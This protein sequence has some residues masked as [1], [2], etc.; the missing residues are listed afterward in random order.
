M[1]CLDVTQSEYH[2]FG[3]MWPVRIVKCANPII[4]TCTYEYQVNGVV[5]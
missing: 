4:I 2:L 1:T 5:R 3:C